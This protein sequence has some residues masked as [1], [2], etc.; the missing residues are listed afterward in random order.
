MRCRFLLAV[1]IPLLAVGC[2]RATLDD[3]W[4]LILEELADLELAVEAT[5]PVDGVIGV[6]RRA[7]PYVVFNRPLTDTE[8]ASVGDMTI[9][10]LG[11]GGEQIAA[12]EIEFD[13]VA[14]WFDLDG[15]NRN[16]DYR[17]AVPVPLGERDVF[18][19]EVSTDRPTGTAFHITKEAQAE[20]VT[21][22]SEA[23]DANQ[24]NSFFD[25]MHP[26]WVLRLEGLA[27]EGGLLP[28]TVDIGLAPGDRGDV[29]FD[30]TQAWGY[31]AWFTGVEIDADGRFEHTQRRVFLSLYIGGDAH[32]AAIAHLDDPT[33]SGRLLL[34]DAGAPSGIEDF[35][36]EGVISTR[37]L[38]RMAAGDRPWSDVVALSNPDVDT[39][40]NGIPDALTFAMEAQPIR[41]ADPSRIE[42]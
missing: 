39:N 12:L 14:A 33:V 41:I 42:D 20:V 19:V 36:I 1:S 29:V 35:R 40:D 2:T 4:E 34:D 23:A 10:D 9:F 30:V 8:A 37:W 5:L 25:D 31:T 21:F 28:A 13:G 26:M 17:F 27:A 7:R 15:L 38:R 18:A 22:G 32:G 6:G 24:V 3:E 11:R 16:L